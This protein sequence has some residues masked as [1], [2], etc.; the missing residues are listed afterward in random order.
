[1]NNV[2]E[3]ILAFVFADEIVFLHLMAQTLSDDS[4]VTTK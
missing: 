2:G 4:F 1:M 3:S